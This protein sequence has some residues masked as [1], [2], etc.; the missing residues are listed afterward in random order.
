M[1]LV[2]D[3]VGGTG[4]CVLKTLLETVGQGRSQLLSLF[5]T[6]RTL[7]RMAICPE[8]WEEKCSQAPGRR[9]KS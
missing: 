7:L 8:V 5:E 3:N 6:P 4:A 1:V 2:A 9:A